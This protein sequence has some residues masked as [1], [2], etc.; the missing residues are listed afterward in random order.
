MKK[1][2]EMIASGRPD[3]EI[4]AKAKEMYN[5]GELKDLIQFL[6]SAMEIDSPMRDEAQRIASVYFECAL[7][8]WQEI[9]DGFWIK[10][11][12]EDAFDAAI[13]YPIFG[14]HSFCYIFTVNLK[15]YTEEQLLAYEAA[16]PP[17]HNILNSEL[18]KV[19]SVFA[20]LDLSKATEK[21]AA[22][23]QTYLNIWLKKCGIIGEG[24]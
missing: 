10:K 7:G 11:N 21:Y 4:A 17:S 8:T 3:N 6:S 20:S 14:T 16:C 13:A 1:L 9:Q 23:N 5:S 12:A 18:K 2:Y 19:Y 22:I 24:E 15:D